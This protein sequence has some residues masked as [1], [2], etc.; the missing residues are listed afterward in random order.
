MVSGRWCVFQSMGG[1][2]GKQV[3]EIYS[4]NVK[5][6]VHIPRTPGVFMLKVCVE[7]PEAGV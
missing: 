4:G 6:L 7:W 2:A 1:E 3:D 5:Q